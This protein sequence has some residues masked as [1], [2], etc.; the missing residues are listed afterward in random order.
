MVQVMDIVDK[1]YHD[2]VKGLPAGR[3]PPQT[4]AKELKSADS[5]SA[6][7]PSTA[8]GPQVAEPG[9]SAVRQANGGPAGTVLFQNEG[10]PAGD[11]N[12]AADRHPLSTSG[13]SSTVRQTG[14]DAPKEYEAYSKD[15]N[16]VL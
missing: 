7:R 12:V 1:D 13:H 4:P 6:K 10:R 3:S 9:S 16:S 11:E 15:L 14:S 5:T 2:G 8:L